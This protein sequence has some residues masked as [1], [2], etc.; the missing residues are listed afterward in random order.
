MGFIG[1]LGV[2]L[3]MEAVVFELLQWNGTTKNDGF[4]IFWWM[5]T[6]GWAVYGILRLLKLKKP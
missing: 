6:L 4:F 2:D 3:F 5:V 1:W